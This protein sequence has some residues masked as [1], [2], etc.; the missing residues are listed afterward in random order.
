LRG[1]ALSRSKLWAVQAGLAFRVI[2]RPP[3]H[4]SGEGGCLMGNSIF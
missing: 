1:H 4:S 3:R 2:S